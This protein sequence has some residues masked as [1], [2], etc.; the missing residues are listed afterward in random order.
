MTD[1]APLP[2]LQHYI[3]AHYRRSR[4]FHP[5]REHVDFVSA[6]KARPELIA[7][8]RAEVKRLGDLDAS[9]QLFKRDHES[10][11]KHR[12]LVSM[13]SKFDHPKE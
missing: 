5:N 2:T 12:T 10:Q 7:E 9:S 4:G 11:G 6:F 8:A 13:L 1:Q 3:T